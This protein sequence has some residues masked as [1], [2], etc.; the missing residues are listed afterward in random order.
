MAAGTE[1]AADVAAA[2][3]VALAAAR[4]VAAAATGIA[5]GA[6]PAAPVSK[7]V[8]DPVHGRVRI[9]HAPRTARIPV[10]DAEHETDARGAR[11]IQHASIVV[12][13]ERA[14]GLEAELVLRRAPE[15]RMLLR[16]TEIVRRHRAVEIV[17]NLAL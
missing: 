2:G 17:E 1:A 9:V 13:E 5:A 8:G 6:R 7:Q 14:P 15:F 12:G 10:P 16:E 3:A 4:A 11:R